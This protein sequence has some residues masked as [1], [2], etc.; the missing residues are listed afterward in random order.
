MKTRSGPTLTESRRQEKGQRRVLLRLN[1]LD[2]KALARVA[3]PDETTPQAT[4]RRL[5][6]DAAGCVVA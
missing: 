2:A 1:E 3:L 4:L 6:R 5:I